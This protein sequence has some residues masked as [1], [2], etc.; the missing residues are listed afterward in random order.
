MEK[1]R[2]VP[3]S[4]HLREDIYNALKTAAKGRKA[5]SIV[6]DSITM[7]IENTGPFHG[8]YRMGFR[9]AIKAIEND[10]DL[11]KISINGVPISK[12]LIE[13]LEARL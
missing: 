13:E 9:D 12:R 5:S 8:G 4:V 6:R 10:P 11:N 1:K 3:Y 2:L 7:Y